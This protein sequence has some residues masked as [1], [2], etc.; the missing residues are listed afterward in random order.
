MSRNSTV[1]ARRWT[2]LAISAAL[3]AVCITAARQWPAPAANDTS[4][5]ALAEERERLRPNTD[6]ALEAMRQ[7]VRNAATPEW[8][9]TRM[10]DLQRQLG[11]LWRWSVEPRADDAGRRAT[12]HASALELSRWPAYLAAVE[13]IERQPGIVIERI[14]FASD[15]TGAARKFTRVVLTLRL[16]RP[17]ARTRGNKERAAALTARSLFSGATAATR[18]RKVAPFLLR[19]ARRPPAAPERLRS[20]GKARP[21]LRGPQAV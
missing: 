3:C 21:F 11:S 13:L 8:S 7:Q 6:D 19:S 9:E 18:R 15:G 10:V 1:S 5:A 14:D 12:V 16:L 4:L 20:V 17:R 2:L